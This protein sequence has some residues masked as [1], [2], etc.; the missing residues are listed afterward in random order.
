MSILKW[1]IKP[2]HVAAAKNHIDVL[3]YLVEQ[4]TDINSEDVFGNTPLGWSVFCKAEECETFLKSL[5]A[6]YKEFVVPPPANE[7]ENEEYEENGEIQ[8]PIEALEIAEEDN[9]L[10][11]SS[12]S[13]SKGQDTI[14]KTH[15][16]SNPTFEMNEERK[17]VTSV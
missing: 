6:H 14:L 7:L 9:E 2:V 15:G 12:I 11:R 3:K 10:K 16:T 8:I 5:N 17:A 13:I 1:K 4:G